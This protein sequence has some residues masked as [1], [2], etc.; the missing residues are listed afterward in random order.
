[1]SVCDCVSVCVCLCLCMS[2]CVCLC[3]F[4]SV[5]VS[6]SR[7]LPD[8]SQ[9]LSSDTVHRIQQDTD[10]DTQ[11]STRNSKFDFPVGHTHTQASS[12]HNIQICIVPPS[13]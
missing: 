8:T 6:V 11:D 7:Y 10:T 3:L 12:L 13:G 4:V 5:S 2:V 9:I 1:M